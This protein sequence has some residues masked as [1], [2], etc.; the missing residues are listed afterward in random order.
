M[1]KARAPLFYARCSRM[2]EVRRR[3]SFRDRVVTHNYGSGPLTIWL[4]NAMAQAWY[5]SD[6]AELPEIAILRRGRLR[7]GARVFD[8]GAHHGV[9]ALMLAREVGPEGQVVAVEADPF[10][11]SVLQRN[12]EL[13]HASQL[14]VIHAAIQDRSGRLASVAPSPEGPS[15]R[16]LDWGDQKVSGLSLD[17]MTREFG[18]PDV[19]FVDVDGFDCHVLRGGRETLA[20]KPDCFIEIHVACGLEKEGGSVAEALSY[21]PAQEWN[22]QIASDDAREFVPFAP[23]HPLIAQRFFLIAS[24]K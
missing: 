21:F 17:D 19:I 9:V 15:D 6:W 24:A 20:G 22:L 12:K 13:N 7:N 4:A 3:R 8:L 14:K 10:A 1:L 23:D 11:F 5:D 18:R 16:L 2:L